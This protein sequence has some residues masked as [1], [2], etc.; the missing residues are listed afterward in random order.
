MRVILYSA[1]KN[2]NTKQFNRLINFLVPKQKMEVCHTVAS[3]AIKLRQPRVEPNIT[4]ALTTSDEELIDLLAIS[5]LLQ[6]TDL[7]LVLPN[8]R[9]DTI[10]IGHR[11]QPRF[12]A[13]SDNDLME[14]ADVLKKILENV[15]RKNYSN[16]NQRQIKTG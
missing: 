10:A 5:D 12:I 7:F 3:M 1:V 14:S 9:A 8:R 2:D 6:D 15:K 11:L 4:I 13:Y 16:K